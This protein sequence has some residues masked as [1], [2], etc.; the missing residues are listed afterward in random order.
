M[1]HLPCAGVCLAMAQCLRLVVLFF[2]SSVIVCHVSRTVLH[3]KNFSVK[4]SYLLSIISCLKMP[5]NKL[6]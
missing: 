1:S 2:M 4:K 3:L 5:L 6:F